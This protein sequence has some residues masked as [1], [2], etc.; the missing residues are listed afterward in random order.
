ML[1][2]EVWAFV[3]KW[4]ILARNNS[5][6]AIINFCNK[7]FL[8]WCIT[9]VAK[10][11]LVNDTECVKIEICKHFRHVYIFFFVIHADF[12]PNLTCILNQKF[13]NIYIFKNFQKCIHQNFFPKNQKN[14]SS[15]AQFHNV[16][17]SKCN[18]ESSLQKNMHAMASLQK[19]THMRDNPKVVPPCS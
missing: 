13:W 6:W 15:Y 19:Y 10:H 18:S 4:S 3:I 12:F 8:R 7:F 9:N 2:I 5:I 14:C 17:W 16:W 11:V 1:F